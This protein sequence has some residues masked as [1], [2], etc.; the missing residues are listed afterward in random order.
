MIGWRSGVG[1]HMV[2]SRS[3]CHGDGTAAGEIQATPEVAAPPYGFTSAETKLPSLLYLTK[4][5]AKGATATLV[6]RSLEPPSAPIAPLPNAVM[7][8][9]RVLSDR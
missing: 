5:L 8:G 3:V 6:Q 7:P 1:P 4:D 9:P 2:G